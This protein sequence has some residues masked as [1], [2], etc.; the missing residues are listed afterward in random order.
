VA[1]L[2]RRSTGGNIRNAVLALCILLVAAAC[3]GEA[4][5][6]V[7]SSS[8]VDSSTSTT[9]FVPG[10]LAERMLSDY[11]SPELGI[12]LKF[13]V[14]WLPEEN[15]EAGLVAFTSP[16]LPGDSFVENFDIRVVEVPAE[17]ELADL[18]QLDAAS[19][20][21]SAAGYTATGGY[22]DQMAGAEASVVA[23]A[24]TTDGVAISVLRVVTL[25]GGR[26]IIFTFF[27]S[28]EEFDNFG[29]VVQQLID[30][31]SSTTP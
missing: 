29:P 3:S 26:G 7:E 11:H 10:T 5:A 18:V 28:S 2:Y 19:I 12:S 1:V 15:L 17:W 6:P 23:L 22:Q 31:V 13:P 27:A 14:D 24:G 8:T 21:E 25:T 30:S 9:E 20:A 4:D 16:P